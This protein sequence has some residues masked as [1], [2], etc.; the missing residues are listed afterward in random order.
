VAYS[1][2]YKTRL[3]A[4]RKADGRPKAERQQAVRAIAADPHLAALA[5]VEA[6][7][8]ID[9]YLSLRD[10]EAHEDMVAL[11]A[12]MSQPLRQTRI[13]QEQLGFALNRLKR[14]DEAIGVLREVIGKHGQ[15][16]ETY[17]LLGRVYKDRWKAARDAGDSLGARGH[18]RASIEAYLAGFE[19]DWRD[20]YPGINAVSLMEMLDK[21]DPR[22]KALLPV[23]QYAATQ[24]ARA[25]GD[26]WDHATLMEAAILARDEEAAGDAA[27][28]AAATAAQPWQLATTIETLRE[29]EAVRKRRGDAIAWLDEIIASLQHKR[30]MMER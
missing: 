22:Q 1:Q 18:L 7:I 27:S 4:A 29:I 28:N 17:G 24:R 20:T 9:L 14:Y 19:A 12:R 8:V 23:V 21:P 10:V 26:Y 5:D 2:E 3:A 11:Y 16:S 25:N 30:G 15:S 13:V 6:G